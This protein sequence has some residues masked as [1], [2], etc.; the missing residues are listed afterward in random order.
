MRMDSRRNEIDDS[1]LFHNPEQK[2]YDE[3]QK[4]RQRRLKS[5]RSTFT[6]EKK[7]CEETLRKLFAAYNRCQ[8]EGVQ[9]QKHEPKVI[10][11]IGFMRIVRDCGLMDNRF[12]YAT[13]PP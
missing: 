11:T 13:H 2:A 8:L 4:I 7:E 12:G 10:G 1:Q 6:E 5:K 3:A 9:E